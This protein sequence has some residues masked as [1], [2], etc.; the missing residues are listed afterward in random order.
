MTSLQTPRLELISLSPE[1]V[2]A[3]VVSDLDRARS[4][5]SFRI[6]DETFRGDEYVLA[7]R[8]A[9]LTADSSEE[10]WLLRAAVSRETGTVVGKVG[11]HAPP[12]ADGSVE[13][14]YRVARP[15]RRK[16]L[17]TEMAVAMIAWA[18]AQ[19]ASACIASVR[20]DNT[21]SLRLIEGLGFER[22][23]EQIDEIDGLEWIFTLALTA[24]PSYQPPR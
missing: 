3:L 19:G 20:P 18:G 9:Q 22:T 2:A 15:Y 23:G 24:L 21:P 10:P 14:G 13:I 7:L 11:F 16:G 17:A 6:E 12:A 4:L 5:A 8:H 1:L